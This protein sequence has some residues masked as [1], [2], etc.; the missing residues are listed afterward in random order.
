M[1][2]GAPGSNLRKLVIH[3]ASADAVPPGSGLAAAI[4]FV[5]TPGAVAASMAKAASWVELAIQAVRQAAEPNPWKASS[6][7]EIA[8]EL[9]RQIEAKKKR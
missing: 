3:K 7:E 9:M 1:N 8:T 6:D 2:I 5:T 4:N